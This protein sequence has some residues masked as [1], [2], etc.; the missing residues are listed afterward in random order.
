M[1]CRLGFKVIQRL[2]TIPSTEFS[3]NQYI[4]SIFYALITA[5]GFGVRKF[6]DFEVLNWCPD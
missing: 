4:A 2:R 6:L 3:E 5:G 1:R